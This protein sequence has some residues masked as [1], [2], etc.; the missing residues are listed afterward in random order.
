MKKLINDPSAV[1]RQMLEGIARQAPHVAI[2]G[3]E[4]VLVR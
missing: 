4:N 3:D 1:V 2:L